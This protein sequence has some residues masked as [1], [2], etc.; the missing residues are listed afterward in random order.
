MSERDRTNMVESLLEAAADLKADQRTLGWAMHRISE[1]LGCPLALTDGEK[2]VASWPEVDGHMWEAARR[3]AGDY[4]AVPVQGKERRFTLAA[5]LPVSQLTL[6]RAAE[7]L[8][9][10]L[11]IWSPVPVE[12]GGD[13][14]IASILR[15]QPVRML[16]TGRQEGFGF[17]TP[18]TAWFVRENESTGRAE[19]AAAFLEKNARRFWMGA[20]EGS[21]VILM[22]NIPYPE[23]DEGLEQEFLNAVGGSSRL[24]V[25]YELRSAEEIRGAYRAMKQYEE[26]ACRI[27]RLRRVFGAQEFHFAAICEAILEGGQD[28]TSRFRGVVARLRADEEDSLLH[29]LATFYLDADGSTQKTGELLFM[30]KNTIKYR[31]HKIRQILGTDITRMPANFNI[32]LALALERILDAAAAP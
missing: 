27:Y 13:A 17:Q 26:T 5:G 18:K 3:A 12:S 22:E 4:A 7:A 9:L 11:L 15:G 10:F 8:R 1:D 28:S 16:Q 6:Q 23:L 19:A 30:H 21:D 29:T 2:I 25:F 32:Y 24:N 20:Y 31:L 14:M